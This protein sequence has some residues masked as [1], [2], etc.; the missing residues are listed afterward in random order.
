MFWFFSCIIKWVHIS[1]NVSWCKNE[2]LQST[3]NQ[4]PDSNKKFTN[5]PHIVYLLQRQLEIIW[6]L[7]QIGSSLGKSYLFFFLF[8]S[9]LFPALKM[10]LSFPYPYLVSM[11]HTLVPSQDLWGDSLRK[12]KEVSWPSKT[13][14]RTLRCRRRPS[15]SA[16][17]WRCPGRSTTIGS[18]HSE[19]S[20]ALVLCL[21]SCY[22]TVQLMYVYGV[23]WFIGPV[24]C[25]SLLKEFMFCSLCYVCTE[26]CYI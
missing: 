21:V 1:D 12:W 17:V 13:W 23:I 19:V 14:R 3:W 4:T 24:L 2:S 9:K 25:S 15:T 16:W 26:F 8:L 11:S 7:N 5:I 20:W 22:S 18:T 6:R 10:D